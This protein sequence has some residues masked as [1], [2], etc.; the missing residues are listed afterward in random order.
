MGDALIPRLIYD[1]AQDGLE[2]VEVD[3]LWNDAD[4]SLGCFSISIK[5]MTENLDLTGGFFDQRADDANGC[6]FARTIRTQQG[7]EVAGLN[8]QIYALQSF[9]A[10]FVGLAQTPQGQ[11]FHDG[12]FF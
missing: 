1:H 4:Q 6:G 9:K 2:L 10:V 8:F 5:V 12:C 7:K 11:G 3:L